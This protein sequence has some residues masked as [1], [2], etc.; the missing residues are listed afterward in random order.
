[1]RKLF[2]R[3]PLNYTRITSYFTDSRFHPILKEYR[4]HHA[5]DYAAPEGT[6]VVA[7]A[8][9]TVEFAGWEGGYGRL[10]RL[11]H[12]GKME[13]YYGH[14]SRFGKDIAAGRHVTQGEVIA[15]VGQTGMATGPHLHFEVHEGGVAVNPLNLKNEPAEPLPT[16]QQVQ[17]AQY[18]TGLQQL[19]QALNAGQVLPSFNPGRLQAAL[20]QLQA[21]GVQPA[22]R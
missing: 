21:E 8:D 15:Y 2:L 4:P 5:V 12:G 22:L 19:D 3:S 11:R 14:L 6:P 13:T 7:V 9:G 1:M 10:L 17:F 16:G 18:E 20:A